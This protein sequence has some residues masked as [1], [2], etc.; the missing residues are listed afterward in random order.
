MS[1]G[2]LTF[3]P[4]SLTHSP[5]FWYGLKD[6][7][8]VHKLADKAVCDRKTDGVTSGR[9]ELDP[10]ERGLSALPGERV[11]RKRKFVFEIDT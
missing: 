4:A 9:R 10:H 7:F 11:K 2:F 1:H 3:S 8:T 6:L 5:S